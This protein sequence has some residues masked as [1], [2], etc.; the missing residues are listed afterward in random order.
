MVVFFSFFLFL[1]PFSVFLFP[2]FIFFF[3]F[4]AIKYKKDVANHR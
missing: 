2:I 4:L 3:I 1:L